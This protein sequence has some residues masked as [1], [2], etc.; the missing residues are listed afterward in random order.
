M[1]KTCANHPESL[2]LATCKAC[3]KSICL[4]CVCD[5]KEGTFCSTKCVQVFREVSDW[6]DPSATPGATP[7]PATSTTP[8]A[9]Q[10]QGSI[11]D[12]AVP[13][14][15]ATAEA[16]APPADPPEFEP[17]VT[18][19]TKWR[20]I[21][22]VCATHTDTQAVATCGACD[23]TVCALCVVEGET[24]TFCAACAEAR[25]PAAPLVETRTIRPAPVAQRPPPPKVASR[26]ASRSGMGTGIKVAGAIVVVGSLA[27]VG[28]VLLNK[29]E[30]KANS[31]I[32]PPPVTGRVDPV[33]NPDPDKI[34]SKGT[35][36]T[37]TD[38]TKNP[39]KVDPVKVDP[40]AV[41]PSKTD[42]KVVVAPV[43]K[44]EP[45]SRPKPPG[46]I[47][48]PWAHQNPGTWFRMKTET[49]TGESYSDIVLKEKTAESYTLSTAAGDATTSIAPYWVK[50]EETL[51][52]D[53][54]R[55][56]CEIRVWET[57]P[58][59]R[60]VL[61]EGK[62]AG[63]ILKE[64]ST[65]GKT[66]SKRLWEHTIRFGLRAIDCLVV[67]GESNGTPIKYW[68]TATLPIGIVKEETTGK[69]LSLVD[70]GD[71]LSTRPPVPK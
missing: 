35:D 30:T 33:K 59:R 36:P 10:P 54:Q 22:S 34:D 46:L 42:P 25:K 57:P 3:E 37:R 32:T 17:L 15:S 62:N 21:G 55:W 40:S 44:P 1:E 52:I 69:T 63:A 38:P 31:S 45:P 29:E 48:N 28:F 65:Q 8:A 43:K 24:G 61:V 71:D 47:L 14:T 9:A 4:M 26:R 51:T 67:E 23:R 19:G 58:M 6:V 49:A 50:G 20:M 7:V 56:L 68:F 18:P 12:D 11:F 70:F 27:A 64:E 53:G 16:P 5:E 39:G 60:W 2:A 13:S 41:V 66:T